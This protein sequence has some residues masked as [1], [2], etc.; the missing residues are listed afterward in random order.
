MQLTKT[1]GQENEDD[2]DDQESSYMFQSALD[3]NEDDSSNKNDQDEEEIEMDLVFGQIYNA[4]QF[5]GMAL[6][7]FWKGLVKQRTILGKMSI[8]FDFTNSNEIVN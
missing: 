4:Q 8:D 2:H 3:L 5:R 7:G 1:E 6:R